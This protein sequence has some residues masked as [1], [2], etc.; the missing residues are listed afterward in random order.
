M[1]VLWPNDSWRLELKNNIPAFV[2]GFLATSFQILIL[3]EFEV[4]FYGNE[5]VYGFVLA[6]W[7]VGGGFGSLLAEKRFKASIG[8]INF[9][10]FSMLVFSC[11]LI[12]LRFSRFVFG[13]LPT[14]MTGLSSVVLTSLLISFL[15]SLPLGALFVYNVFWLKGN[16]VVVYQLES[17]G[18]AL[19]GLFVYLLLIPFFSNWQAAALIMTIVTLTLWL[20]EGNKKAFLALL[21]I[22]AVS[23]GLW[24]FDFPSKKIYWKPFNLVEARDSLYARLQVIRTEN[25]VSFFTNNL[26]AFNYPDRAAAEESVHFALLQRPE[27]RKILLIGGGLNGGLEQVLQYPMA[28][29]DYVELDPTLIKLARKHLGEKADILSNSRIRYHI[30]DGRRF[31]QRTKKKYEVIISNLPEPATAQVNRFYTVEFF[32]AVKK[33]LTPDGVF[34]FILPSSEN[35]LSDELTQFLASIYKS[36]KTAFPEIR[37]IPG[38]NN[39]FLA[40]AGSLNDS[41]EV[42]VNR[43]E[44]LNLVTVYFRPELLFNRLDPLK[45][46]YLMNRIQSIGDPRLNSDQVPISYFFNSLLWSSQFKGLEGR[47]LNFFN[48]LTRFWLF[49]LPLMMFLLLML[50]FLVSKK[51]VGIVCFLP[52]MVMG[53]TTIVAEIG[54]IIAFQSKLG[55]VYGKIALLLTMFMFGLFLGST[56]ARYL[57]SKMNFRY[58]TC[59]QAGFVI[60]LCLA[61][62]LLGCEIESIF[63]LLLLIM[64]LLGGV[65]FVVSNSIY[66]KFQA[67]YGLGYAL[68]LFG[69]FLGALIAT[70]VFIPLLGLNLLFSFLLLLNSFCLV[71]LILKVSTK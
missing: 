47:I 60:F 38:D 36:L 31:L 22:L 45:K 54:F 29:V 13:Y 21:L 57:L 67:R 52:L 19:S 4:C 55:L 34:S 65:L 25:Q 15:V 35:Y 51:S 2:L 5:L 64:G 23:T 44:K 8:N 12:L 53:F 24:F 32:S 56:I 70:S 26:L 46:E 62:L 39:V 48:R 18:A 58:L 16:L 63:Y 27:A 7:L 71:F 49:D 69:S 20:A 17:L 10:V 68:D 28:E 41:F 42:L 61:R 11:L 6:F 43:L 50:I 9:Y 33:K 30:E 1:P 66:L 40:S 14:E 59:V 37:I 3:R